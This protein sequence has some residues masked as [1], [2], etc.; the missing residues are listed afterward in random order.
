VTV[1]SGSRPLASSWYYSA[2]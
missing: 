1:N 2:V